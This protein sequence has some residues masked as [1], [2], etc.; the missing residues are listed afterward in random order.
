[1]I[2]FKKKEEDNKEKDKNKLKFLK[3]SLDFFRKI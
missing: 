1:M 2:I 3:K